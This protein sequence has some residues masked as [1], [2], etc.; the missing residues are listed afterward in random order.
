MTKNWLLQAEYVKER[1]ERLNELQKEAGGDVVN[2]PTIY[3]AA[4]YS[5]FTLADATSKFPDSIKAE[6]PHIKWQDIK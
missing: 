3:D 6:F 1:I 4:L 2:N 5:L